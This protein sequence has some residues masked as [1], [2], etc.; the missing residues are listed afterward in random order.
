MNR[1]GLH[2]D[3][4]P[5]GRS[6]PEK[7]EKSPEDRRHIGRHHGGEQAHKSIGQKIDQADLSD[8]KRQAFDIGVVGGEPAGARPALT[9]G[10]YAGKHEAVR[11]VSTVIASPDPRIGQWN[12]DEKSEEEPQG[13]QGQPDGGSIGETERLPSLS[14]R[15]GLT[16]TFVERQRQE[17]TMP[18]PTRAW[19]ENVTACSDA[20]HIEP[21]RIS[22][23]LLPFA[24][25]NSGGVNP[26]D[27]KE[28]LNR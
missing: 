7:E 18:A 24:G 8:V 21:L 11:W 16:R 13:G 19:R 25:W 10:E 23:S 22:P 2:Q 6:Q 4:D 20:I 12:T 15:Q 28:M 5:D 1:C 9:S 14:D 26:T 3:S 17:K 27:M